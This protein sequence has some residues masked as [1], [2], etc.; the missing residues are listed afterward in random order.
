MNVWTHQPGFPLITLRI[1]GEDGDEGDDES[2]PLRL[3]AQQVG[4]R[5]TCDRMLPSNHRMLPSNCCSCAADG[6]IPDSE[7]LQHRS[8]NLLQK[9]LACSDLSEMPVMHRS[10]LRLD[11]S[12]PATAAPAAAAAANAARG[13][14]R[15]RTSQAAP[16]ATT[17]APLHGSCW[18][19][20]PQVNSSLVRETR[21]W[22]EC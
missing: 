13:G 20:V 16:L 22:A 5:R 9:A 1:A 2:R 7:N 4:Q 15:W 10:P 18:T 17:S 6:P 21:H 11:S 14:C 12:W 3:T 19:T 8:V